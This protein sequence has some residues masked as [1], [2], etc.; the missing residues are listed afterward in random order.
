MQHF[1]LRTL[2]SAPADDVWQRVTTPAGINDELRPVLRMTT[3]PSMR[4][5]TIADVEPTVP[6][7]RS[8][9][10][11]FGILPVDYDVIT[12]AEL[13]PGR[14]FLERSHLASMRRW[15]HERSIIADGDRCSVHDRIT[16]EL[17]GG[18]RF[19]ALERLLL[20]VV[21]RLFAHRHVRIVRHFARSPSPTR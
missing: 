2:I 5:K 6:L 13:D 19:P 9:L 3:P 8:W 7:G 14:R 10:L 4:G 1:E 17:R 16:F 15:E 21:L 11:L 20:R 12:V 18:A